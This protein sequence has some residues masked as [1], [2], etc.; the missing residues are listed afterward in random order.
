M[1]RLLAEALGCKSGSF[2]MALKGHTGL[3]AGALELE[4]IRRTAAVL[5]LG[6]DA[7]ECGMP[8]TAPAS[9]Y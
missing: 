9:R 6:Q 5:V 1:G 3:V 7:G 8:G 2:E 4:T